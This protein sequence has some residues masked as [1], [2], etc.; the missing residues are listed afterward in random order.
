MN[1]INVLVVDDHATMLR[2]IRAILKRMD[3]KNVVEVRDGQDAIE[4]IKSGDKY[5]LIIS[6]W[7]MERVTGYQLLKAVR[8]KDISKNIPFIMISAESCIDNVKAA[9]IAGVDAYIV[10][11]FRAN[12]LKNAIS[13]LLKI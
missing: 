12:T 10:K 13:S 8:S 2:I 3:I 1:S 5:D 7:I 6:D 9:K 11:P 4:K